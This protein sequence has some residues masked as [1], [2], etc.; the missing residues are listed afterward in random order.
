MQGMPQRHTV[1]TG[2]QVGRQLRLRIHHVVLQVPYQ[3]VVVA[4]Q[5]LVVG[6]PRQ[7]GAAWAQRVVVQLSRHVCGR[8]A[9]LITGDARATQGGA[10]GTGNPWTAPGMHPQAGPAASIPRRPGC[11]HHLPL[12]MQLMTICQAINCHV[13][14]RASQPKKKP[15]THTHTGPIACL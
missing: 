8:R 5:E 4:G 2:C 11:S 6:G 3:R 13:E 1:R 7:Q 12:R 10:V 9:G 14:G 15:H